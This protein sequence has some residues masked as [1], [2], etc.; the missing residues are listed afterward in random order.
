MQ[1]KFTQFLKYFCLI[2]FRTVFGPFQVHFL[3][4]SVPILRQS[5][6]NKD[7]KCAN[8]SFVGLYWLL[9]HSC[10]PLQVQNDGCLYRAHK[11]KHKHTKLSSLRSLI[12]YFSKG[13]QKRNKKWEETPTQKKSTQSTQLFTGC[14]E[15]NQKRKTNANIM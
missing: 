13:F 6:L 1:S 8:L 3:L 2:H 4:I 10:P 7:K 11:E 9:F 12:S 5:L 15:K 14:S